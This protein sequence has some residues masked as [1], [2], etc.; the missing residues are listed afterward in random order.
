M[1]LKQYRAFIS[2]ASHRSFSDAA[3]QTGISQPTLSRLIK[4]LEDELEVELLDRY[5]RPLQ[6][7]EVG[8]FYYRKLD[9]LIHELDTLT[10][11]THKMGKP[12]P[13]LTIGF[14]PTIL[15]G[16]LP[17][18]IALVKEHNPDLQINLK[19]I[20]SYEQINALKLGEIDVGLGRFSM[21]DKQTQQI[22]LRKEN[23]VAALPINHKLANKSKLHLTELAE[24]TLILYNRT[25]LPKKYDNEVTEPL[26]HIFNESDLT[27]YKTTQVRELQIALGLV[28]ATEGVTLVP[29]SLKTERTDKIAYIP[30]D[31]DDATSPIYLQTLASLYHPAVD[32]LLTVIYELYDSL[33]IDYQKQTLK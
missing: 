19:D 23:Y 20:S 4:Q 18:I 30:L 16:F 8:E 2:V 33:A 7:T 27:P 28:A 31:Q 32:E 3:E 13:T 5:H 11:L 24:E 29:E 1:T 9:T 15:Y 25:Y 14:V 26:L 12:S 6:L 22:L 21:E 17:D 10:T